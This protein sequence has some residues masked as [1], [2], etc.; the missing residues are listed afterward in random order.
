MVS[1]DPDLCGHFHHQPR[2][3]GGQRMTL[4][5]NGMTTEDLFGSF[6]SVDKADNREPISNLILFGYY[7]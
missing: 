1:A 5:F 3:L 6:H 7:S 2:A 4:P